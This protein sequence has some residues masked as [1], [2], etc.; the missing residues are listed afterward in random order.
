M[1]VGYILDEAQLTRYFSQ[2]GTVTDC[3]LP[4]RAMTLAPLAAA[5]KLQGL[6]LLRSR[7]VPDTRWCS[8]TVGCFPGDSCPSLGFGSLRIPSALEC[9]AGGVLMYSMWPV[10]NTRACSDWHCVHAETQ[11]RAQQGL[12][13][14]HL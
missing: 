14:H 8:V 12:R 10:W 11:V 6:F 3:Y 5:L 1:N 2:Y 4:V 9:W 7:L 13:V